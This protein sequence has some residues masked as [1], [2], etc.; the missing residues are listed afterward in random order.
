MDI[1]P[2]NEAN[3]L[4]S[5]GELHCFTDGSLHSGNAGLGVCI[6]ENG[7]LIYELTQHTGR[8]SSVF[9]N[10]VLAIS[11]CAAELTASGTTAKTIFIHSDSQ[12][13]LRALNRA[14][15]SSATVLDCIRHFNLL[16]CQTPQNMVT[17]RWIPGHSGFL[18]NEHADRLAKEGS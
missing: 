12:A 10:E 13:A 17:L 11:A 6:Y 1:Q 16:A 4:W 7:R 8:L 18:G 15:T 5:D 9:Q 2:S 14:C 3:D